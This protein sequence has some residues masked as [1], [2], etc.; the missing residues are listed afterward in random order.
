MFGLVLELAAGAD[1]PSA[2][3]GGAQTAIAVSPGHRYLT[4]PNR[5]ILA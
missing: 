3:H 1:T 4:R 2:L 5:T